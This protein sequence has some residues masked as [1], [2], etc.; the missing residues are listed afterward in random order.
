MDT[1]FKPLDESH[2]MLIVEHAS[3]LTPLLPMESLLADHKAL[4]CL[5]STAQNRQLDA[6]TCF[7]YVYVFIV[8]SHFVSKGMISSKVQ[9]KSVLTKSKFKKDIS[10]LGRSV[11]KVAKTEG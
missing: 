7:P 11:S 4:G 3:P 6:T 1:Y 2:F 5:F 9:L 10:K 8:Y